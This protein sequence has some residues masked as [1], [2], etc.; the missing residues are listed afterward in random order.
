MGL[1]RLF[2]TRVADAHKSRWGPLQGPA[3]AYPLFALYLYHLKPA[4]QAAKLAGG[5]GGVYR[6][7]TGTPLAG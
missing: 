1:G 3:F 4:M 7:A 5:G 2:G 6:R